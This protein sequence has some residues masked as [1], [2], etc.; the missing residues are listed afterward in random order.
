MLFRPFRP[1]EL[2]QT[3]VLLGPFV[4]SLQA[5]RRLL[6]VA[7]IH[8]HYLDFS[9]PPDHLLSLLHHADF[10]SSSDLSVWA[11]QL[12][13][14]LD[15]FVQGTQASSLLCGAPLPPTDRQALP[16]MRSPGLPGP[17]PDPPLVWVSSLVSFKI[18]VLQSESKRTPA[19]SPGPMTAPIPRHVWKRAFCGCC[20][21]WH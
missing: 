9:P 16:H 15:F 18:L 5:G 1:F 19:E 3:S 2:S 11:D 12:P 7:R 8:G 20:G 13:G 6:S 4:I 21:N 17:C 14:C 10:C